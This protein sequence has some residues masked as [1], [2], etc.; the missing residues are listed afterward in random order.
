MTEKSDF[1]NG[2]EYCGALLGSIHALELQSGGILP[3]GPIHLHWYGDN[4]SALAWLD[5]NRIKSTQTQK[6][7]M[8]YTS[9]RC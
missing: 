1:Q 2:Q 5:H 9:L 7:F 4:T 3:R 8:A 6:I